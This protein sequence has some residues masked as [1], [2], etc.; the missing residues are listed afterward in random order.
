MNEKIKKAFR[1]M[2][3]AALAGAFVVSSVIGGGANSFVS[4]SVVFAEEEID[5]DNPNMVQPNSC[6]TAPLIRKVDDSNSTNLNSSPLH[7][8]GQS[9][10]RV[11]DSGTQYLTIGVEKW[12]LYEAFIPRK[13]SYLVDDERY[14]PSSLFNEENTYSFTNFSYDNYEGIIDEDTEYY[15]IN[16]D[17]E[18]YG[19]FSVDINENLDVAYVTFKIDDYTKPFS[20]TAWLSKSYYGNNTLFYTANDYNWAN[21]SFSLDYSNLYCVDSI[22]NDDENVKVYPYINLYTKRM[23]GNAKLITD[24][25]N[26]NFTG[27]ATAKN[28]FDESIAERSSDGKYVAKFHVNTSVAARKA[29]SDFKILKSTS[30]DNINA[31]SPLDNYDCLLTGTFEPLEIDDNGYISVTY[32]NINEAL[33][34]KYIFFDSGK[35]T[36]MNSYYCMPCIVQTENEKFSITDEIYNSGIYVETNTATLPKSTKLRVVKNDSDVKRKANNGDLV[37]ASIQWNSTLYKS[38]NWYTLYLE[39]E[40]GN[41]IEDV[42]IDLFVPL[43]T[44][45]TYIEVLKDSQI[46][47]VSSHLAGDNRIENGFMCRANKPINGLTVA[48]LEMGNFSNVNKISENGIYTANAYFLH[49]GYTDLL[50]MSDAGLIKKVYITVENGEKKMYFKAKDVLANAYIGDIHCNNIDVSGEIYEDSVS[51][52]DFEVEND[53]VTSNSGYNAYTEYANIKGGILTLMDKS[54]LDNKNVYSIA[55]ASP[56]M[57]TLSGTPEPYETIKKDSLVVWLV[58]TNL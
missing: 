50:S 48:I 3:S 34:G 12:S 37:P 52:T 27:D 28:V 14:L 51:Y 33:M 57:S 4:S 31:D 46:D 53:E 26:C 54:Y 43:Y 5:K 49:N 39:D 8:Y 35:T 10:L 58:F 21:V 38:A 20:F 32:D 36:D 11:D 56:I 42:P 15:D 7:F 16:L 13:Q 24:R 19:D 1:A 22:I 9:I 2:T 6:Y 17:S 30:Y 25:F 18:K 47:C 44:D 41:I 29:Y 45:K 40:S 55:V 23:G